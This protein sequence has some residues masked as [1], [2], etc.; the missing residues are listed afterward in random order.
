MSAAAAF[1]SW[2]ILEPF[3][4][5][6]DDDA[7]FPDETKAPVRA[8]G[9]TSW[10][11]PFRI[12]FSFAEPPRVSRLYVQLPGFPGPD[13]QTP[14]VILATHRH[15]TLLRVATELPNF[16][17]VQ[18]FFIYSAYNPSS[19]QRLPPCTEPSGQRRRGHLLPYPK[20][21][22]GVERRILAIRSMG[23]LCRGEGEEF[24]VAELKLFTSRSRNKVHAD[25][26]FLKSA[27]PAG[28]CGE[29]W[30]SMRVPI[31]HSGNP[32]EDDI[33]Q[34]SLWNTDD[35]IPIDRWLCWIDYS[36]GVLF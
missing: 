29:K 20:D 33:R 2:A 7:S 30:S 1:P 10:G 18:D 22:E 36:R 6:R 11:A 4:F 34:L 15:L 13:K 31:L 12:A 27:V 3:V 21:H 14:L 35:V 25:I 28:L 5:R 23:L 19:L 16:V 24:A 17:M 8:S 32:D 26:F 9:T